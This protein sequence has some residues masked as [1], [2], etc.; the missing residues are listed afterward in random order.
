MVIIC[1]NYF[2]TVGNYLRQVI[3][4]NSKTSNVSKI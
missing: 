3:T 2:C 1:S 4:L